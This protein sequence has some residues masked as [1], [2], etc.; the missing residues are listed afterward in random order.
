[1]TIIERTHCLTLQYEWKLN[2]INETKPFFYSKKLLYQNND[3]FRVGVKIFSEGHEALS[4]WSSPTIFFLTTNLKKM[5][6]KVTAVY[7]SFE[8]NQRKVLKILEMDPAT[9]N[10]EEN[11]TRQLF[12]AQPMKDTGYDKTSANSIFTFTVYMTGISD[13]YRTCRVDGLLSQQ[14]L[15]TVI[16]R[17]GTDFKLVSN[18]RRFTQVHKFI[19]AARSPIFAALFGKQVG[20]HHDMDCTFTDLN[21]F[22]KFIY[23]GELEGLVNPGLM[24]LAI[25]Y[26]IKTLEDLCLQAF[27]KVPV[28][29]MMMLALH[30]NPGYAKLCE[31][32]NA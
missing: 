16:E 2:Q 11:E 13:S 27:K 17:N 10:Q 31:V 25:T 21:Q 1:M 15:S 5:G 24:Q 7:L 20:D 30:F 4:Y 14:L 18:D 28:N 22:V 6:L 29:R 9:G 26:Q 23:T 8:I 32:E 12:T 19:L 3:V